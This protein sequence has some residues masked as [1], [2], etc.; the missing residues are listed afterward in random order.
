MS[1][2]GTY[3]LQ[4]N[5]GAQDSIIMETDLLMRRIKE[6][7]KNKIQELRSQYPNVSDKQLLDMDANWM[8]T[9]SAIEKSHIIFIKATYK[10]FVNIAHEYNKASS[11]NGIPSLGN[12]FSFSLPIIGEFINDCVLYVKLTGLSAVNSLDK[13][14][15]VERLGHRLMKRTAF[16]IQSNE[17]DYYTSDNYNV[18]YEYKVLPHK[19]EAY[20]K[21]IGQEV[22]RLGY[23]TADATTDEVREYRYFGSGAQTFKRTQATIEMWIPLLFWFKDVQCSLPNF[24][25][26]KNQTEIEVQFEVES[27]LVAYANYGGG[28]SYVVP[29]VS[30]CFLY[31]NNVYIL[32]EINKIFMS[33]FGYQLIRVHRN[34][35]ETVTSSTKDVKLVN[36]KWPVEALYIGFR[37]TANLTNSQKWY[38]N[39]YMVSTSVNQAVVTGTSTVMVSPAVYYEERHPIASLSLRSHDVILYPSLK[40]EF[41]QSYLP[42]RFGPL[43]KVPKSTGWY[44]INFNLEPWQYQPSGHFNAS[45]SRELYL[46]YVSEVNPDDNTYYIK[47]STPYDVV[48]VAECINFFL[49]KGGN[50]VLRFCT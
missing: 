16:K 2:G 30:E 7:S 4:N 29:S 3:Q 22:P 34:H 26:P 6:I 21:N 49:M 33:K 18:H 25:L 19:D 37:P 13:V 44:M 1:T 15:Y 10:P 9:L 32:P 12:T 20:L 42:Y 41:Y 38:K 48:V 40:P 35:V 14:R 45:Q 23:L 46:N 8:P 36:I 28:G 31:T 43:L 47:P 11:N 5:T 39:S 50:A 24:I 17:I 27:K